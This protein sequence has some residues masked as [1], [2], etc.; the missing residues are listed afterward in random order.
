M[1]N[2]EILSPWIERITPPA[3]AQVLAD[4]IGKALENEPYFGDMVITHSPF[5]CSYPKSGAVVKRLIRI[6][7]TSGEE[8]LTI[9]RILKGSEVVTEI[10]VMPILLTFVPA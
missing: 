2:I 10:E 3:H 6:W 4:V 5:H 9:A 7:S 1:P 8:A